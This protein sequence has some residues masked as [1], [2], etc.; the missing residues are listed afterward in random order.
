M[1]GVRNFNFFFCVVAHPVDWLLPSVVDCGLWTVGFS[2]CSPNSVMDSGTESLQNTTL[3]MTAVLRAFLSSISN[4]AEEYEDNFYDD[5]SKYFALLKAHNPNFLI[6]T[7]LSVSEV[8]HETTQRSRGIFGDWN[9]LHDI[10]TQY[11][12]VLRKRWTKKSQEQRKRILL[13]AWPN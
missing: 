10:V 4:M 7:L 13:T 8:E 1:V 2:W 9:K 6:P 12:D 3:N 11:E 5:T